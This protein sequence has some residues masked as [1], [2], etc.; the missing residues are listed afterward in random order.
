MMTDEDIEKLISEAASNA[1]CAGDTSYLIEAA[2]KIYWAGRNDGKEKAMTPSLSLVE[3]V[4]RA[5]AEA[6][7][8]GKSYKGAF[9]DPTL[10]EYWLTSARAAIAA[11]LTDMEQV[12][13]GMERVAEEAD[14]T[15]GGYARA[16]GP[17]HW[18][19]MLA[20]YRKEKLP[21]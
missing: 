2:T 19:V 18:R 16:T 13:E 20:E 1:V 9:A 4:A 15:Y 12:S 6:E 3:T 10:K 5:L 17:D 8:L 21:P 14:A 7:Y 11:V